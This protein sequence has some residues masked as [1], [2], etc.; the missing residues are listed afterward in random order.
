MIPFLIGGGL[1]RTTKHHHLRFGDGIGEPKA[2]WECVAVYENDSEESQQM[3]L[4]G[5]MSS[6]IKH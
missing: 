2:V 6:G 4:Q 5:Y 3:V 1:W